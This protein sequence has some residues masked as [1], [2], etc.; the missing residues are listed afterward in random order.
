[1]L[2]KFITLLKNTLFL[3]DITVSQQFIERDNRYVL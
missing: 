2:Q 3:F 1:M